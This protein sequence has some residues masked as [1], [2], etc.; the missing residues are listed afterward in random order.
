MHLAL[1]TVVTAAAERHPERVALLGESTATFGELAA[2]IR[3]F[4]ARLAGA[5]VAGGRVGLLLPNTPAFPGAFY[6]IQACGASVL[7]LNPLY[8]PREIAEYITGAGARLVVT[9]G[10]LVPLLPAG[11]RTLL[12]DGDESLAAAP[13]PSAVSHAVAPAHQPAEGE[14]TV[15]YTAAMHGWARGARLTHGSLS[16]NMHS[17]IV[18]ME[19][20]AEDRVI[21]LLPLVH[22]FGLTVTLNAPLAA[23]ASVILV[24][25]FH[26]LRL[27]DLL[28][29]TGATVLCG[30][31][32]IYLGLLAATER[33]GT[34]EHRLRLAICGGAPLPPGTAEQWEGAFGLPLREGYGLTEASPVCLF[35]RTDRPNRIGT[36]GYAFPGVEVTIRDPTGEVVPCGE[37]GE[38][39][40]RGDNVFAGYVGEEERD[41]VTFH[42]DALRT[43]DCGSADPDGAVRFHGCIKRMFTRNGFNIYPREIERTLEEDPRIA[44]ATVVA[45]PDSVRENEIGLHIVV[46]PGAELDEAAVRDLC[47]AMLAAYK[48]PATVTLVD[49]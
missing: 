42:G 11:T 4:A 7:L 39:C 16:A 38:I 48:Q 25:R 10:A 30:V 27:L 21:A 19:L 32:A 31:P 20:T 9:I 23:G 44:T 34:P 13:P 5:G 1:P 17:T 35:N 37:R 8:S 22:A 36:L 26:P 3:D 33:R 49:E 24:E 28:E 2:A 43:G 41:A 18:A 14:A 45:V 12:L 29:Q 47:R 6:G 46:A 15:I 40:V